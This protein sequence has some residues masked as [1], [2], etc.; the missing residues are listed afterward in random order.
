MTVLIHLFYRMHYMSSL[1]GIWLQ[2]IVIYLCISLNWPHTCL[3]T[4]IGSD[5]TIDAFDA[6]DTKAA[7]DFVDGDQRRLYL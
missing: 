3:T 1:C 2:Y 6:K 5:A 7:V 4:A